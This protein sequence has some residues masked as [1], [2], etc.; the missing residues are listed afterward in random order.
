[1]ERLYEAE[2]SHSPWRKLAIIPIWAV[3]VSFLAIYVIAL[4]ILIGVT[5][6]PTSTV[7]VDKHKN[8]HVLEPGVQLYV[9][10]IYKV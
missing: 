10:P 5:S 9:C 1:M 6:S 4:G 8:K 3:E 2:R 7:V